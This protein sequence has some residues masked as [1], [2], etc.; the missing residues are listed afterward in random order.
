VLNNPVNFVDPLGL[1]QLQEWYAQWNAFTVWLWRA[2]GENPD[3]YGTVQNPSTDGGDGAMLPPNKG[4]A[5]A[6]AMVGLITQL[7]NPSDNCL[8][9]VISPLKLLGFE[10]NDFRD[11]LTQ[12]AYFFDGPNSHVPYSGNIT[13]PQAARIK[14][15]PYGTVADAFA[16]VENNQRVTALTSIT[17]SALT[18]YFTASAISMRHGGNNKSNKALLFHEGLHGYGGTLGGTSFFD[19][20]LKDT[21]G[22]KPDRPSSDITNFIKKHCF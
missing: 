16:T 7:E 21:F 6:N 14:V 11:F 8:K 9:R 22:I 2:M 19:D 3:Y 12:G 10:L 20:D 15:G 18:T 5:L 1:I 13:Y 17:T 4:R